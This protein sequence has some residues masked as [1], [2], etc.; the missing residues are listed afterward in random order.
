MVRLVCKASSGRIKPSVAGSIPALSAIF[1]HSNQAMRM[2]QEELRKIPG[3]DKLLTEPS[4]Q[5]L[6]PQFGLPMVT[7]AIRHILDQAR[8]TILDG[9]NASNPET[10]IRETEAFCKQAVKPSLIPVINATGVVIH[11]NLGRAPLGEYVLQELTPIIK[12]YSNLEYDLSQGKRGKRESHISRLLRQVTE[13]EDA[14]VVNN[15]AA[16]LML[17]LKTLAEDKEVIVS[18]G[19]LIEIGGSF[20]LPDIMAASGAKMVEVGTTN[21][22]RISDY[23]NAITDD[24]RVLLK[25]HR[26]NYYIGGFTE[27]AELDELVSLAKKHNLI[28]IY[29]IGSGLLRKPEGLP[30]Q[31]EPDILSAIKAGVDIVCFSGDKLLGGPQAGIIAGKHEY[32]GKIA[33]APMMRALRTG[34]MTLAAL[35]A[36][37][38]C[39]M[40]DE[41]L[42]MKLPLFRMLNRSLEELQQ[43]A[44][45]FTQKLAE[46]GIACEIVA[47]TAF[48]GG[49]TLPHLG[50][51]SVA[52]NIIPPSHSKTWAEETWSALMQSETPV[53]GILREGKLLFE[54]YTLQ[55]DDFDTI[56][57][58]LAK[59][60][61][62]TCP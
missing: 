52:I 14:V 23:E 44:E 40:D 42:K 51:P 16:G 34:K 24:T 43:N 22:T 8:Q 13:A 38:R 47:S 58:A 11:T 29:D 2:K 61:D 57:N 5:N 37:I 35:S 18:R 32:V 6:V 15:N 27:E 25:A 3:V 46:K 39:Y 12:G 60:K 17:S 26:S 56:A 21:R 45:F 31:K 62:C 48:C 55:T 36:V 59:I 10:L 19:E 7:Q 41:A 54:L 1:Q 49:G 53:V 4:I 30:L 20:R 50:I 28:F 33:K 9:G